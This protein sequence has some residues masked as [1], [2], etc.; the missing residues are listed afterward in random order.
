[1]RGNLILSAIILLMIS[2]SAYAADPWTKED[3][4]RELAALT[5]RFIDYKTTLDIARSPDELSE[6][7][8]LLGE[9]PSVGRVNTYF[10]V[11]TVVH[12][13]ISYSLPKEYRKA[14]QYISIG[15]S[16]TA[17]TINLWSGLRVRF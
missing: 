1:M 5:L 3:T 11:M 14:F 16:G 17:S 2:S 8:P 10:A 4:Y 7:N 15:V 13:V 9:H 12:P 6:V